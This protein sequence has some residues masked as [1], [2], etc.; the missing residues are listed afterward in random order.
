MNRFN[1]LKTS[2]T[3]SF[4]SVKMDSTCRDENC[5]C[6]EMFFDKFFVFVQ[7]GNGTF[8][9][10]FV[11]GKSEGFTVSPCDGHVDWQ[12]VAPAIAPPSV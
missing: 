3:G 6:L 12:F 7:L 10:S 5:M 1:K 4:V 11:E 9:A 8:V 2:M